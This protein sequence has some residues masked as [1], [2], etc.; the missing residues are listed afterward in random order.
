MKGK[1][2]DSKSNEAEMTRLTKNTT[3]NVQKSIKDG[4]KIYENRGII[5]ITLLPIQSEFINHARPEHCK[6]R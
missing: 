6:C 4:E 3:A 5:S 1:G 2:L